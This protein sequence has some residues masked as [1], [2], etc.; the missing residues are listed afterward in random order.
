MSSEP[1]LQSNR[2]TLSLASVAST[3]GSSIPVEPQP[4]IEWRSSTD[5][6]RLAGYC[7]YSNA[8]A[9]F[10]D[11]RQAVMEI[12]REMEQAGA[13]SPPWI[14]TLS[15][16]SF[17]GSPR[18]EAQFEEVNEDS[19]E[20]GSEPRDRELSGLARILRDAHPDCYRWLRNGVGGSERIWLVLAFVI[21]Q[22]ARFELMEAVFSNT[23]DTNFLSVLATGNFCSFVLAIT[24]S[25]ASEGYHALPQILSLRALWRWSAIAAALS[26]STA[27][28]AYA[29][30]LGV[31][32]V[33]AV[34][35][36]FLYLPVSALVSQSLFRRTYGL[37]EWLSM[38]MIVLGACCVI[39]LRERCKEGGVF[40]NVL[41][42]LRF[43]N[44]FFIIVS[45]FI[46][47]IASV[48]SER[49][50]KGRSFGLN[51]KAGFGTEKFYIHK[52]H[53]DLIQCLI[54]VILWVAH[55]F[56][57]GGSESDAY[58]G[59]IFGEWSRWSY[60]L[61]VVNVVQAWLAG[62]IVKHFSTVSK[63][64]AQTTTEVLSI[65][66]FDN[67]LKVFK[68]YKRELPSTM[69]ALIVVLSSVIFLAGR[70]NISALKEKLHLGAQGEGELEP[71]PQLVLHYFADSF[72]S[73]PHDSPSAALMLEEGLRPSKRDKVSRIWAALMRSSSILLYILADSSRNLVLAT[74]NRTSITPQS[75]PTA[76]F[77][78]G[79]LLFS[80]I[81]FCD[82][83]FKGFRQ[84]FN[85]CKIIQCLVPGFFFALSTALLS[86]A[87]SQGVTASLNMVLGKV[88]TPIAALSS[89]WILGKLGKPYEWLE[90]LALTITTLASVTFGAL[91]SGGSADSCSVFAMSLV[92]FSAISSVF[93]SLNVEAIFKRQ[94]QEELESFNVKKVR[95]DMASLFLEHCHASFDWL[96]V[97]S[98]AGCRTFETTR[99]ILESTTTR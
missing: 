81:N 90:W 53:I 18:L 24:I 82:A 64:V 17:D 70:M 91:Q 31:P 79:V 9:A 58:S 87:F 26:L 28:S 62:L 36:G 4:N 68:I 56:N 50:L 76:T 83:G 59:G 93:G 22:S 44:F 66:I 37:L 42:G 57:T 54:G 10:M 8:S 51:V 78:V 33:D 73:S 3:A 72:R 20:S 6:I 65:Y 30:K 69:L 96:G 60:L 97:H 13:D 49:I 2:S 86:M 41:W 34:M 5:E 89:P 7:M 47:A 27:M 12:D 88:Y 16:A 15:H 23:N 94:V 99:C 71:L 46:G 77:A 25:F 45:V 35:A 32:P 85:I 52:V 63:S 67:A 39:L 84:G 75:L 80:G 19:S 74:A 14:Q 40:V 61:M 95:L 43:Y 98:N 55:Y 48:L 11:W 92:V 21:A 1:A 29:W 38:G